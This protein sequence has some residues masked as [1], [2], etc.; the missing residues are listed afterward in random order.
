MHLPLPQRNSFGEHVVDSS[1]KK[2]TMNSVVALIRNSKRKAGEI[3][4]FEEVNFTTSK[5][6]YRKSLVAYKT[7]FEKYPPTQ[8]NL[9]ILAHPPPILKNLHISDFSSVARIETVAIVSKKKKRKCKRH[10]QTVSQ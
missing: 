1:E 4:S 3:N 5:K 9:I 6:A 2:K 8:K 7:P 10:D